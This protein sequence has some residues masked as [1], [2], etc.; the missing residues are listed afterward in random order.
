[1]KED[2]GN[3]N[4]REFIDENASRLFVIYGEFRDKLKRLEKQ[5]DDEGKEM[6]PEDELKDAYS[7]LK[8]IIPQMDY[9]SVEMIVSQVRE[10]KLPDEDGARFKEIEKLLKAFEWDKLEEMTGYL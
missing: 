9:D 4:D 3:K 1:M 7:A 6:I 8:E 2:A 5:E 10:Y